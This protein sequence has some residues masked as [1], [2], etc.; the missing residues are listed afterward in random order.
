MKDNIWLDFGKQAF[1]FIRIS[2]VPAPPTKVALNLGNRP[3]GN[4]MNLSTSF[5]ESAT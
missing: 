5:T 2:Q 3:T 1:N 4:R